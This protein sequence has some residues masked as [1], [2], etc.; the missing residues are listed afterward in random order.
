MY[1][2]WRGV[3][4]VLLFK[5]TILNRYVSNVYIT[6]LVNWTWE[7]FFVFS[8]KEFLAK[9]KEDFLRKWESPPQ[10]R[11]CDLK[12]KCIAWLLLVAF[13]E[14]SSVSST[15]I[16]L[17]WTLQKIKDIFQYKNCWGSVYAKNL[18]PL[19]VIAV[20]ISKDALVV[21]LRSLG[22]SIF[23]DRLLAMKFILTDNLIVWISPLL[24]PIT[25][26]FS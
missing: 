8:V 18:T 16:L 7:F 14:M 25:I 15:Q 11:N 20:E 26:G 10:V 1:E 4:H 13:L 5:A 23:S 21:G 19:F 22:K 6:C 3:Y 24:W 9:A 12:Y 17:W 2:N